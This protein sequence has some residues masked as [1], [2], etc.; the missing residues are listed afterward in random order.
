MIALR[1]PACALFTNALLACAP[2]SC[3]LLVFPLLALGCGDDATLADAGGASRDAGEDAGPPP[4]D[5]VFPAAGPV[6]TEAGRGSF[7]FGAATAAAQIED[8]DVASDWWLWT[9][10]EPEGLGNGTF[11][12]EAA[13]GY[14][15][16]VED[17]ALV[18]AMHLDAY[19]LNPSWSRI[20]P[21]RD[22]VSEEA[23]AHYDEVLDALVAAGIK[24][25]LTVHHFSS[26]VWVD[27]P[28][29]RGVC[30]EPTDEDL[31]GWDHD[32]GADQVIEEIAEHAALLAARYGDRVDEWATL[33]E[34]V[35]YLLASYGIN[36]FP[37]GRNFLLLPSGFDRLVNAFRN[38][39]RA[40]AAIYDAIR[41]ADVIDADG[42]GEAASIG[43]SL[44]VG[45][46]V[47]ARRN[48]PSSDPEDIAARDRLVYVYH[49]LFPDSL[50][51]GTFDPDLDGVADE[52]HPE[53]ADRLD[54]LGVQYY[55]RAGVTADPPLVPVVEVTPC[56]G[57]LDFG[58]CVPALDPTKRVP[59]MQYEYYEPGVYDVLVDFAARWPS[60]PMTVTESGIATEVGRR[61]AEHVV[62]SLEQ[63]WR[64]REEGVDVRGYYHW[65]LM[66]NFEWAEGYEP[67][68]GLYAV[69]RATF[70][71]TPTEGAVMLGDIVERRLLPMSTR[72]EYGGVGPM[73]PEP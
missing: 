10:P 42:D 20:E 17:V 66:D 45:S 12:D 67:R 53:W 19:R 24:P 41:A 3:P 8:M 37:P 68:F 60:L 28:R 27:D 50:Q 62:R 18:E 43:L 70:E 59:T 39:L 11:V 31:C 64:A 69:D 58:A 46:W 16:A 57:T 30:D 54:F 9:L 22:A 25:M 32:A 61:R 38:Y 44:S 15:R 21:A 4:V 29:R 36:S 40:H 26:P 5:I 13:Q 35:N 49:Y 47:P 2:L 71:R 72:L 14:T 51:N 73:T 7:T 65:S 34:P 52:A 55:F 6:A 56:F 1:A 63:I 33:N 23:L 48:L